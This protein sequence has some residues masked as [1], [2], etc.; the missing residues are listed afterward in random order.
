MSVYAWISLKW[1]P[2]EVTIPFC[3]FR[4]GQRSIVTPAPNYFQN[5]VPLLL[6]VPRVPMC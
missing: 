6:E 4:Q 5:A 3:P 1:D 2:D